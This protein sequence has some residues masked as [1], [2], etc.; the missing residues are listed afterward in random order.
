M[1]LE[2]GAKATLAIAVPGTGDA[3]RFRELRR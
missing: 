1:R 3:K 2:V